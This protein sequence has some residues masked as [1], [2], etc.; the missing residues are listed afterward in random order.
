MKK[1]LVLLLVG[2]ALSLAGGLWLRSLDHPTSAAGV[3]PEIESAEA[4][5]VRR[6]AVTLE[7][8]SA[9]D[10][11]RRTAVIAPTNGALVDPLGDD[12]AKTSLEGVS[13]GPA[14]DLKL[15]WPVPPGGHYQIWRFDHRLTWRLP[16]EGGIDFSLD[17]T[18]VHL[19]TAEEPWTVRLWGGVAGRPPEAFGS[20]SLSGEAS[21]ETV[22]IAVSS[23][24]SYEQVYVVRAA[25][26]DEPSKYLAVCS[27]ARFSASAR[28]LEC[29]IAGEPCVVPVW[30]LEPDGSFGLLRVR[31]SLGRRW[32]IKAHEVSLFPPE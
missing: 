17:S 26:R 4:E 13:Q 19:P 14:T 16:D 31:L 18:R 29:P 15:S 22:A 1:T 32:S 6:A 24:T 21:D 27:G 2:V 5:G 3:V 23:L 12:P 30:R 8:G 7:A 20:Y 11:V 10:S 28:E 25:W 9:S